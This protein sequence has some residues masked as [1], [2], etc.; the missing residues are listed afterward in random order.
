MSAV[1]SCIVQGGQ[2]LL[3]P[4]TTRCLAAVALSIVVEIWS[5]AHGLLVVH[6]KKTPMHGFDC[7]W[8]RS[9]LAAVSFTVQ[10]VVVYDLLVFWASPVRHAGLAFDLADLAASMVQPCLISGNSQL[11]YWVVNHLVVLWLHGRSVA[12]LSGWIWTSQVW[13]A[14]PGG[15]NRT[16]CC[17]VA[18]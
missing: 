4:G 7:V 17:R 2:D 8:V 14:G 16:P 18:P 11:S 10:G 15:Q 1:A 9:I 6:P 3:E 5:W 12:V 13:L